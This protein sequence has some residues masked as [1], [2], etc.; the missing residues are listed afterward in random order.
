MRADVSR[1]AQRLLDAVGRVPVGLLDRVTAEITEPRHVRHADR[2][3][4]ID[5]VTQATRLGIVSAQLQDRVPRP[6]RA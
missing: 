6:R 2:H 1:D 3:V 4:G 5:Q